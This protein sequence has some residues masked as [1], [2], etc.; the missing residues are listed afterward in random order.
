M[1]SISG[2]DE[3]K[4]K[5]EHLSEIGEFYLLFFEGQSIATQHGK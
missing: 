4:V 2:L 1:K 3:R 5:H